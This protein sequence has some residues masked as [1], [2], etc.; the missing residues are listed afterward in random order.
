MTAAS[1]FRFF[2]GTLMVLSFIYTAETAKYHPMD[3]PAYALPIMSTVPRTFAP[4]PQCLSVTA[5][6]C[7]PARKAARVVH[8]GFT[9]LWA[10][11]RSPW[12]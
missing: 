7:E 6:A 1:G 2:M 12:G 4:A 10:L 3:D 5:L 11:W 8:G 9:A